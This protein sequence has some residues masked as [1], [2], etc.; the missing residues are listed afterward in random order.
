MGTTRLLLFRQAVYVHMKAVL[1]NYC[2]DPRDWW[3]DY[4]FKPEDVTLYDRSDDK[5]QRTFAA[6]TFKT[7]NKGDVDSD[8]LGYLIENYENLPDVFL[9][10]K[11]NIF[12]FVDEDTLK[13]A[14]QSGKFAPLMKKDH[15]IYSDRFGAVNRYRGGIYEER[16]NSWFFNAGLDNSGR[17]KSWQEWA[18]TFNLPLT[19]F[20]P[21]APGG[22][23][24]LT[25][26]RV[27]RYSKD[28]YIKMRDTLM[29][30]AHPVEAHCCERSYY[31]LWR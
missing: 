15:R 1:V 8:K 6:K 13:T 17:F 27:H 16:A 19:N 29:Y 30:A 31:L 18:E 24:L 23:Y 28:F 21:F 22:S 5:I 7:E 25:K 14:L 10:S 26:E 2:F 3:L 11:T 4:G 20:I 12:K 9:W